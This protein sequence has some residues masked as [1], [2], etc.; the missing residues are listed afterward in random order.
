MSV[1]YKGG[2]HSTRVA[3]MARTYAFQIT[4][5]RCT[6]HRYLIYFA[7][8]G[9]VV[10]ISAKN[11]VA[12]KAVFILEILMYVHYC[13][14]RREGAYDIFSA[15]CYHMDQSF[16]RFWVSRGSLAS[17][18]LHSLIEGRWVSIKK[19]HSSGGELWG[20]GFCGFF[21]R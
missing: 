9:A 21:R 8:I 5:L 15:P 16:L 19:I 14:T 2:I 20:N 3:A 18:L 10:A 7:L 4:Y 17:C 1:T 13:V 6:A 11:L 12:A